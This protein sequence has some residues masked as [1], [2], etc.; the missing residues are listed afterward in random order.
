MEHLF[1]LNGRVWLEIDGEKVLGHGR[2]ELLERIHESGS[3][4][5]AA[6]QMKMSYRQAWEL[7]KH[8]NSF[9]ETPVVVSHR[10][11]KGGGNAVVTPWG[12]TLIH[13]FHKL[14]DDFK[15]FTSQKI[16]VA[17]ANEKHQ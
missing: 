5:Q 16:V 17:D 10:G 3:I 1:N 14:H 15:K 6:M 11:G 8:I 9:F 13:E 12:L 2:V 7:I 4:R